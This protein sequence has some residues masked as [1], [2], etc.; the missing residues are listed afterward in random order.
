MSIDKNA[1]GAEGVPFVLDVER[2]KIREFARAVR[3]SHPAHLDG[4][5]P[6]AP[7]TFLTTA[8][9]WEEAVEGANPWHRVRMDP[10]RGMHA[11]QEYIFHGPPPRAGTRLIGRS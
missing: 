3:S 11:E 1:L 8:F 10:R 9:F 7:A 2:G 5:R 6:I 4:E